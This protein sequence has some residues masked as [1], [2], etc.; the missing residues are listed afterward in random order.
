MNY[1]AKLQPFDRYVNGSEDG[2]DDQ[3]VI[4]GTI[5]DEFDGSFEVVQE[6]MDVGRE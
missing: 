5:F 2:G 6:A 4:L 3:P 1:P